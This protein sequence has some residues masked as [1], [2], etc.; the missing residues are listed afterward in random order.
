MKRSRE[1]AYGIE[2]LLAL[3]GEGMEDT[4]DLHLLGVSFR[5]APVAVREALSFNRSQAADLLHQA[6]AS[7]PGLQAVVLSTCNRSEFYL[8]VP[9]DSKAVSDWLTYLTRVRPQAPI[10]R[11][12]CVRYE[13]QDTAVARH[14]FGVTCG[15][16]SAILGDVQILSQV[17]EALA[18]AAASGTLGSTLQRVFSQAVHAGKRARRE[19]T[20]GQG[21][22]SV[23]SVL[24][25]ML[26]ERC[27][28]QPAGHLLNI[29]IIGAGAAA[30][31]IGQH[32]AK[33][34]LGT[35]TFINRTEARAAALAAYCAGHALPWSALP[36]ALIKADVV[37]AATAAPQPILTR[38]VL[39]EVMQQRPQH[40]LLVIDTGLPR[41][42]EPGAAIDLLTI[43]AIRERQEEGLAQRRTAIPAVERIVEE[44][45]NAWERWRASLPMERMLKRLYQRAVCLSQEAT[46]HVVA[47][48]TP[49]PSQIERIIMQSFKHLL[50]RHARDLRGLPGRYEPCAHGSESSS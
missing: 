24:A 50:H 44:E 6:T 23:G 4:R 10:L 3:E 8:A 29:L 25:A 19:T 9:P 35:V 47:L 28:M 13:L 5:T 11:P 33:H 1:S 22:A 7:M 49:A 15:L 46:Q 40:P 34:H 21:A 42:V 39:D 30:R 31:N 12:D 43:D 45:V 20:V 32:L 27:S 38:P 37:I 2:G 26:A 41:N 14:L 48:D 16:D 36:G 17:K 18:V